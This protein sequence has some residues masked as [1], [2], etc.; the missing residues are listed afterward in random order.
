LE[1][2]TKKEV[3]FFPELLGGVNSAVAHH[4]WIHVLTDYDSDGV[5][6]IEVAAFSTMATNSDSPV[7]NF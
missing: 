1:F 3:L 5:G 6:E 2:F 4:D 7:M